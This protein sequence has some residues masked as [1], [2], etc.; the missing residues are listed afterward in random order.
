MAIINTA[1]NITKPISPYSILS[2]FF[3]V[4]KNTIPTNNT[5]ATSFQTLM[6]IDEYGQI[7]FCCLLKMYWQLKWYKYKTITKIIFENS[8]S[9]SEG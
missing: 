7:L 1:V 4:T 5:V 8:Q 6:A 2:V 9:G 3:K